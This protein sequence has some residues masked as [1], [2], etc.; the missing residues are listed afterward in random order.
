VS[1]AAGLVSLLVCVLVATALVAIVALRQA[2]TRETQAKDVDVAAL[3]VRATAADEQSA[4]RGFALSRNPRFLTLFGRAHTRLPRDLATLRS[5]AG[6]HVQR[7]RVE[8]LAD[9]LRRYYE[10]YAENVIL[11]AQISPSAARTKAAGDEEKRYSSAISSTLA[12]ILRAEDT[13]AKSASAHAHA[14]ASAAIRV[15]VAA[16]VVSTALVLLFGLWVSR[17]IARPLRRV[18]SASAEVA[19]GDLSVRLEEGG[20]GEAGALV[21]AFNSMTRSLE[22]AQDELIA[23]NEQLLESERH[24]RELIGMVSHELRTPLAAVVGFTTLL[25]ERDFPPDEH[26]RYLQIV[27]TQARRLA[28][29]AGDFLDVQLLDEGTLSLTPSHF[30]LADLVREQVRL[31]FLE[32]ASHRVDLQLGGEPLP[33]D[34]DRDRLAQVVGNLLSNAIKYSDEETTVH[35]SASA[36]DGW[37]VVTVT[38]EGEGIAADDRDRIFEK[39]FRSERAA[40]TVGGTGL[41]LAVA[42][43]I[44]VAHGGLIEVDSRP[45]AGS[46]FRVVIPCLA[47]T[48]HSELSPA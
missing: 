3:R 9:R 24:K 37:A 47:Q 44:V 8:L 48:A 1:I 45:G 6:D 20:A 12:A 38:D 10:D 29:L 18:A 39:F 16:L 22:L 35:V 42:R 25:L 17:G 21:S 4:L 11:I 41:G 43:E 19:A 40:A 27:D 28:A 7:A 31:F 32:P 14:V 34:A 23:Q 36:D 5:L 46:T 2:G 30:D 15:G 13:R 26:R 33:V